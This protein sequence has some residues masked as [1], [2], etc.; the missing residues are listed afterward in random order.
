[1]KRG[2]FSVPQEDEI[3]DILA[4][5]I[6][7]ARLPSRRVN[8]PVPPLGNPN[9]PGYGGSKQ[10][11][12]SWRQALESPGYRRGVDNASVN[13]YYASNWRYHAVRLLAAV[14]TIVYYEDQDPQ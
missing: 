13:P 2:R 8:P 10:W 6:D 3:D 12:F 4:R 7:V 14:N 9:L 5:P 1:M 11:P